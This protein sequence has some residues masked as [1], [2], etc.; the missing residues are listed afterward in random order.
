MRQTNAVNRV[1]EKT[2]PKARPDTRISFEI[3]ANYEMGTGIEKYISQDFYS[4]ACT[5]RAMF[6]GLGTATDST[7]FTPVNGTSTVFHSLRYCGDCCIHCGDCCISFYVLF[8]PCGW[9]SI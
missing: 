8:L 4:K 7:D 6:S 1:R 3:V 9:I 5:K 2:A